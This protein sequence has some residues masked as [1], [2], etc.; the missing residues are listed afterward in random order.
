[1]WLHIDNFKN[2]TP[3]SC[4]VE[5][6]PVL[7]QGKVLNLAYIERQ[8]YGKTIKYAE[9]DLQINKIIKLSSGDQPKHI[10]N[11]NG[12]K[13][14]LKW[15]VPNNQLSSGDYWQLYV[16]L[17]KPRNFYTKGSFDLEKYLFV[18]R[19]KMIGKVISNSN[20]LMIK[21]SKFGVLLALIRQFIIN[22]I[23]IVDQ[24]DW[25]LNKKGIILALGLGVRHL[26]LPKDLVVF[27]DTGTAHLLS[28]SGLH[29]GLTVSLMLVVINFLWKNLLNVRTLEKLPSSIIAAIF[30]II[31]AIIYGGLAG[32]GVATVRSIIMTSLYLISIIL[33]KIIGN[34]Q[35]YFLSMIIILI[36]DPFIS[37]SSSFWLSFLAVGILLYNF[38]DPPYLTN[39]KPTSKILIIISNLLTTNRLMLVGLLPA[40]VLLFGKI[41]LISY[42]ANFIA[43][44]MINFLVLPWILIGIFLVCFGAYLSKYFFIIANFNLNLLISI[45]EYLLKFSYS[46]IELAAP[47]LLACL[48]GCIG[49]ILLIMPRGLLNKYLIII[50]FLPIFFHNQRSPKYGDAFVSVLDVSQGLATVIRLQNHVLLYDTGPNN[51]VMV[52][53]LNSS[54]YKHVDQAIISHTDLDHIGGLEDLISKGIVK[55]FSTSIKDYKVLNLT[56][57]LCIPDYNWQIDGVNFEFLQINHSDDLHPMNPNNVHKKFNKN[58][59]SCVLKMYTKE[60]S[61]LFTGDISKKLEK[62][63][64]KKY[65]NNLKSDILLIPHHGSLSSSSQEFI[66]AVAPKYAVV[67]AGYL[68]HYGHPRTRVLAK[69]LAK[70]IRILNTIEH[71]TIDFKFQHNKSIKLNNF[72]V[73][74]ATIEHNCYKIANRNF[75]NY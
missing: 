18:Q 72:S 12:D 40:N 46:T 6:T 55:D 39:Q 11:T 17:R 16:Q 35:I 19:I 10:I 5:G 43:I 7:V 56:S 68:N 60:H 25:Q 31:M 74:E 70:N 27:R 21:H 22:K 23:N 1:M 13:V 52:N 59:N 15:F 33:R 20:N 67:S 64:I 3:L 9:F 73:L 49:S 51:K 47:S 30:G 62:L 63:L 28:V 38:Q 53:Y 44:P 14:R 2:H 69:Y 32:L 24:N 34:K 41:S 61:M 48:V 65:Y 75:W 4:L 58:D 71:G 50:C 29:V 8:N 37:L 26:I 66:E 57:K 42:V 54:G 45:L 36:I